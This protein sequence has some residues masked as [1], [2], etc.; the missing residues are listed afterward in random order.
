MLSQSTNLCRNFPNIVTYRKTE[1]AKGENHT[2]KKIKRIFFLC[3]YYGFARYLPRSTFP[4][5]CFSKEIRGFICR[6]LFKRCGKDVN[7]EAGAYFGNGEKIE[8]GD[9]SGIGLNCE[10]YNVKIG[11][12]VMMGPEVIVFY[13]QHKFDRT[14]VPMMFQGYGSEL[15]VIIEDDVW[16]GRRCIIMPGVHIGEGAIIAAG[17][18]V[19]KDVPD[20]AIVGGVPARIRKYRKKHDQHS[21]LELRR[22]KRV[23]S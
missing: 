23:G 10:V 18:V 12:Y 9:Y 2:M 5:P 15:T 14:N 4:I 11:K 6:R 3:L 22:R 7:V 17:S 21:T 20:F 19:T 8:L 1:Y 13:R 16:I